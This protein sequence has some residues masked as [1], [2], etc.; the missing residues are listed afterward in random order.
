[1]SPLRFTAEIREEERTAFLEDLVRICPSAKISVDGNGQISWDDDPS[2][3]DYCDHPAGCNLLRCVLDPSSETPTVTIK[4]ST[5][6]YIPGSCGDVPG[7]LLWWKPGTEPWILAHELIHLCHD[8]EGTVQCENR[9]DEEEC[10]AC[11]ENQ[12]RAEF[13]AVPPRKHYFVDSNGEPIPLECGNLSN[14]GDC[15]PLS[16]DDELGCGCEGAGGGGEIGSIV[17]WPSGRGGP[18]SWRSTLS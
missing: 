9:D 3:S 16:E 12:I 11:A 15:A 13:P 14:Y 17:E 4:W 6:Q 8:F 7:Y 5:P 2:C 10:T 18:R 1:V